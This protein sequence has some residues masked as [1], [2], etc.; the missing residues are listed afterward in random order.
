MKQKCTRK[1]KCISGILCAR[2]GSIT[3]KGLLKLD[4]IDAVVNAAKPTLMGSCQGVDG[5]VHQLIDS[6]FRAQGSN[7]TFKERIRQEL[8]GN[9]KKS[10]HTIRCQRGEAV[11][12]SGYSL[13]KYVIHVVGAKFDGKNRS[14]T[15]LNYAS[16]SSSRI[17][18]LESC[19]YSIVDILKEHADIERV[20]VPVI[21]AGEYGFPFRLAADIAVASL[22][23]ALLDWKVKDSEMF[24]LSGIQ[25]IRFYIHREA[26]ESEQSYEAKFR[27]VQWLLYKYKKAFKNDNKVVY[28]G[29]FRSNLQI[30][31]DVFRYD[32]SRGYFS[33]ARNF[34]LLITSFRVLC[35]FWTAIKDVLGEYVWQ[36]RRSVVEGLT[37]AKALF[38]IAGLLLADTGNVG[39]RCIIFLQILIVY[40]LMDT[41]TYL[42][43][44]IIMVDVQNPSANLIRSLILLLLNYLE[45][46]FDMAF[47]YFIYEQTVNI[48]V[49]QALEFGVLNT[50]LTEQAEC[51]MDCLFTYANTGLKFFFITMVFG[52][53]AGHMKQRKFLA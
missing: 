10:E 3:D 48:T 14:D 5:A 26:G 50:P 47:L 46:S 18:Q 42:L 43:S 35:L 25:E 41:V 4:R 31:C 34:R 30:L 33:I 19:Y 7:D 40:S 20:A 49:F 22:G 2:K 21:S 27:Y 8:D 12:T 13:C 17:R 32:V 38:P 16:C 37:F 24:E 1:D 36:R 23:N 53:L 51:W 15:W 52:Y 28:Q 39:S 11:L 9:L 6:G 45:T 44:L 29:S